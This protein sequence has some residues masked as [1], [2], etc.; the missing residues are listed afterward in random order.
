[1]DDSSSDVSQP[2]HEVAKGNEEALHKS[3]SLCGQAKLGEWG[4][5]GSRSARR[6]LISN[7]SQWHVERIP[8][9]IAIELYSA[10]ANSN[11]ATALAKPMPVNYLERL[12]FTLSASAEDFPA[13]V[14]S[15]PELSLTISM[16]DG[17][18]APTVPGAELLT[19]RPVGTAPPLRCLVVGA[20]GSGRRSGFEAVEPWP[21]ACLPSLQRWEPRHSRTPPLDCPNSFPKPPLAPLEIVA[22]GR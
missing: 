17:L 7:I 11:P 21:G 3:R 4:R 19:L 1:M 16:P 9:V 18:L 8:S 20:F 12:K 5:A 13:P 15:C 22:A 10:I 14:E 6:T 2:L